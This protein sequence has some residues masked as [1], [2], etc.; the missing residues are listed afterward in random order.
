MLGL[1][2]GIRQADLPDF[3]LT[4]WEV[5]KVF[6]AKPQ[7]GLSQVNLLGVS[8]ALWEVSKVSGRKSGILQIDISSVSPASWKI[9]KAFYARP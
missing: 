7:G 6:H 3:I 2:A 4:S 8:P 1:K 5:S 9:S